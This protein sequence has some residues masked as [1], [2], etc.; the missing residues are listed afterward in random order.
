MYPRTNYEMTQAQ[1]DAILG[2]CKPTP[3]MF[4]SG[5]TPMGGSPQ[6]NANAAWECLGK[7]MG[8]DHMTVQPT[9]GK[10]NR[11]F[12]AVP[13]ETEDQRAAR[14]ER[15]AEARREADIATLNAEI[16]ERQQRLRDLGAQ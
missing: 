16:A 4:L 3:V 13:S 14:L 7:E 1:L 10:G 5:G 9:S 8:F 6:E 11:F 15:E 12:T 2:A